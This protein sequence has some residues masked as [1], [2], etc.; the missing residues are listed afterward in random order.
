MKKLLLIV[1]AMAAAT[2]AFT[3]PEVGAAP[4][5][6]QVYFITPQDGAVVSS[7]FKVVMG[8]RGMGVAPAG[9]QHNNTGHHHLIINAPTPAAGEPIPS[10]ANHQHFGGGQ[11]ESEVSLPKGQHRLQLVLG[12][13]L[14]RPHKKPVVSAVI[15][16]TVE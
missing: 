5:G 4:A 13:F 1:L 2:T 8:L 11:T 7:P 14:H 9:V 15:T 12:D 16:V 6:A 10:D 3:L